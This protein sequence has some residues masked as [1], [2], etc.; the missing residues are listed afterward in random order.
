AGVYSRRQDVTQEIARAYGARAYRT[1]DDALE[2]PDVQVVYLATPNDVHMEQ[3][4]RAAGARKHVLVEKPMALS[5]ERADAIAQAGGAGEA[6]R[7]VG[8]A[9]PSGAST[10]EGA[11]GVRRDRR[12]RVG[13]RPVGEP[14]A[15]RHGVAPRSHP[16]GRDA[17]DRAG[18]PPARSGPV[19]V[20]DGMAD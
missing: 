12:C 3:T 20:R 4:L 2:D 15:P 13:G 1:F 11:G 16:V 6:V 5:S 19:R 18:G 8:C 7:G 10:G 9:V 14:P 17:V